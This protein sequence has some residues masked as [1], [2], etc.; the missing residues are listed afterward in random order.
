MNVKSGKKREG[1]TVFRTVLQPL[2]ILTLL[3]AAIV[4][5]VT[6]L[7]GVYSQLNSNERS[8][9]SQMVVNR[10]NY[11]ESD[12]TDRWSDIEK[13]AR[14]INDETVR[15]CAAG[16]LS[17]DTLE[18]C[19]KEAFKL[20]E[21]VA[22]KTIET[23]YSVKATG[24]YIIFSTSDLTEDAVPKTGLHI[25]DLDPTVNT[26]NQYSDLLLE[27]A[28][29]ELVKT[30]NIST[31]TG[32]SARYEF[33]ANT[34]YGD[35][36]T[37]PYM[38]AKSA[39]E[40]YEM[41]D[42][43]CWSSSAQSSMP[44]GLTYSIP[45]I[46]DDGTVYGVIGIEML[47]DYMN[48][49]MPYQELGD[50]LDG[51]YLMALMNGTTATVQV[52]SGKTRLRRGDTI[53]LEKSADRS[54]AFELNGEK[55]VAQKKRLTIYSLYAP[56]D[57]DKW[58]LL[59]VAPEKNLYAFSDSMKRMGNAGLALIILFGTIGSLV[60]AQLIAKPIRRLSLE[61]DDSAKN[62][63]ASIPHLSETGIQEV[64][65]FAEAFASLSRDA[66]NTSTRF[67]RMLDM[68]S[69]DIGGC[70]FDA[71]EKRDVSPVF[72]TDN[73]FRLLG[74]PQIDP[75]KATL[76][77]IRAIKERVLGD[78]SLVEKKAGGALV[79]VR[80]EMGEK[81]YV[82]LKETR[83]DNR[84]IVMAEDVTVSTIE[85]I[86]IER[87]RDYDLLTG[88]Y[89]RRAFYR[90]AGRM[91]DKPDE[92]G[93]AAVVMMDLDNLK[94]TN[95]TFGHE[96]GDRYIHEAATCFRR[97][98]PETALCARVSGD[99]FNILF[100]GYKTKEEVEQAIK[101]L[102]DGIRNSRFDLPNGVTTRIHVS[103]GIAWYPQDGEDM[104]ELIK[105]A[106]F[107]MYRVKNSTKD[108]FATFDR[109]LY[110]KTMQ[111]MRY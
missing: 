90:F 82:R 27:C 59:G 100:S 2:M 45:L 81:R 19:S 32:W 48:M 103:G 83:I 106:D 61:V 76:G 111:N 80:D 10:A 79:C 39:Q 37:R 33:G 60:I 14:E 29:I 84:V 1:K 105:H 36:F 89:N 54:Y 28:P 108:T 53:E 75:K 43:G 107:A 47:D 49:M 3:E 99:E 71:T 69:V 51:G 91:F 94:H 88:L 11:L 9:L 40:K 21:T 96:W 13:L 22:E 56:F 74:V 62:G 38:A 72:V 57:G 93:Y 52:A 66:V 63:A 12:M 34:P 42:Y 5:G 77:Q 58:F 55:W 110:D 67:L 98:I 73:F 30:M 65:H 16:E 44:S 18:S 85:R 35:Y 23:L 46:L 7:S 8:I 70:E 4:L 101:Q 20:I 6:V 109:E 24:I 92:L 64:D 68:A 31:D 95:D 26:I 50:N 17:M 86:H 104:M 97:S 25:R 87:E 15:L 102:I 78:V 41:K